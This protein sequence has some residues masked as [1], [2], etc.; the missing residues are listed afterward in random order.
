MK[1][2]T[3][4]K[5]VAAEDQSATTNSTK[6]EIEQEDSEMDKLVANNIRRYVPGL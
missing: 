3:P 2:Q 5:S 4:E 6:P 1:K